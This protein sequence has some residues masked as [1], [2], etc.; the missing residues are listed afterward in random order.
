MKYTWP[1]NVREL[2]SIIECAVNFETDSTIGMEFIG[3]RIKINNDK[4]G[5]TSKYI[6]KDLSAVL[7]DFE[8]EVIENTVKQYTFLESREDIVQRVCKDLNISSATLYR[9]VK[10]M[11]IC[12]NDEKSLKNET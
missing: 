11:D 7:K 8:K 2:Q 1:G 3:R 5:L 6:S 12:L 10:A 9:K 4:N